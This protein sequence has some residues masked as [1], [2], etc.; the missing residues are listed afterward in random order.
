MILNGTVEWKTLRGTVYFSSDTHFFHGNILKY[1]PERGFSNLPDMHAGLIKNHNS[2]VGPDDT[3][4]H[5]GDFAMG[6]FSDWAPILPQMNGHK[7]LVRGNHDRS[8]DKMLS[9]GFDESY[10]TLLLKNTPNGDVWC[11]HVPNL[12]HGYSF[13]LCGHVHQ[14]WETH[15]PNIINAGVDANGLMPKTLEQLVSKIDVSS[16]A[17]PTKAEEESA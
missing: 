4:I 7:I 2:V 14:A 9:V 1:C 5:I 3:Y 12:K 16:S 13:H 6:Q 15:A 8:H 11:E 17:A 10:D